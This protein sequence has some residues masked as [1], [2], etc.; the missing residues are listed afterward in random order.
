MNQIIWTELAKDTYAELM[1]NLMEESLDLAIEVNE[2]VEKLTDSL[3]NF[4][5]LCPSSAKIPRYRRCV[6]TKQ[7]SLLYEVRK[8]LIFIIAVIDNRAEQLYF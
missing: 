8:N 3:S 4:K 7:T 2:K 6:I 5:Q 1:D